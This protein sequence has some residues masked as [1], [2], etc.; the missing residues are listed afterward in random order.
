MA[1][2]TVRVRG[3]KELQRDFRKMSARL[4]KDVNKELREAAKIVS[5]DARSRFSAYSGP[6]SMGIRPRVK[7]GGRAFVEQSRRRTTGQRP[8]FGVLQ[9]RKAFL[10]ALDAKQ[11]EVIERLDDMLGRLG[12]DYGF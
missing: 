7:G 1:Q 2:A 9:M 8:D 4:D 3:L 10:P 6:S 11:E 5:D 12:G